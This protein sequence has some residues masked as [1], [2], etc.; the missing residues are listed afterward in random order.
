VPP[1]LTPCCHDRLHRSVSS[2]GGFRP[3]GTP[4]DNESGK[5]CPC[6]DSRQHRRSSFRGMSFLVRP[7][8]SP[9][10]DPRN[11][12]KWLFP[13]AVWRRAASVSRGRVC[14]IEMS[15]RVNKS[16][17]VRERSPSLTASSHAAAR[18]GTLATLSLSRRGHS[19]VVAAT[20]FACRGRFAGRPG[21]PRRAEPAGRQRRMIRFRHRR[22]CLSNASGRA[23]W[24]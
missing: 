10:T 13:S 4:R 24:T 19:H 7:D 3:D 1:C 5:C 8:I 16:R 12:F 2:S 17:S 21:N 15:T 9:M 18:P 20:A 22:C 14:V 6:A 23:V 11:S